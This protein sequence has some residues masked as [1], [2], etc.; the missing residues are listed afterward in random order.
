MICLQV[1]SPK[2]DSTVEITDPIKLTNV[3]FVS[4]GFFLLIFSPKS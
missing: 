1:G 3:E 2:E 4:E